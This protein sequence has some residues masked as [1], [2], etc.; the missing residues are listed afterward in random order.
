[1]AAAKSM[2]KSEITKHMVEK[3]NLP[4]K[5]VVAFLEELDTLIREQLGK[6]GPG[7]ITLP[8]LVKL[9]TVIRP[10]KPERMVRNPATGEMVKAKA[11][12]ASK[13]VRASPLKALKDSVMSK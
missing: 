12:P 5:D 8:G 2:T 10:A 4:K 13:T 3:T 1:M 9:R 11:K 7:I 6:K